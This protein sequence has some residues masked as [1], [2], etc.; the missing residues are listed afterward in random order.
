M[1]R[2]A[3]KRARRLQELLGF[4]GVILIGF[5]F[6]TFKWPDVPSGLTW[7]EGAE[8]LEAA[9]P[10]HGQFPLFFSEHG[11]HEPLLIYLQSISLKVFGWSVPSLRL[12]VIFIS[13]LGLAAT[14]L[15]ARKLF[16]YRV[17]WLATLLAGVTL[18]Q[19]AMSRWATRSAAI[20]V[21]DALI[22]FWLYRWVI[23][24][25][26]WRSAALCGLFT[27]LAWYSY[28]PARLLIVIP[29]L[30]G[31]WM[32]V[33]AKPRRALLGQA[34]LAGMV[35]AVAIAPLAW[36]VMTQPQALDRAAQLSV[37]SPGVTDRLGTWLTSVRVTALMFNVTGEIGWDRNISGLPIFDP[38]VSILMFGGIVLCLRGVRRPACALTL[39]W[40]ACTIPPLTLAIPFQGSADFGRAAAVAPAIFIL[41]AVAA[42]GLGRRWPSFRWLVGAGAVAAMVAGFVQYF[43][44]WAPAPQ[45]EP[46]FRPGVLQAAESAVSQLTVA[47]PPADLYYGE[48]EAYD[49]TADFVAAGLGIEHP[50]FAPRLVE[51]DASN[52]RVAP[53]PGSASYIIVDNRPAVAALPSPDHPLSATFGSALA[54]DGYDLPTSVTTGATLPLAIHWR[55]VQP[56]AGQLVFFAHLLDY[57]QKTTLAELDQN[58]FPPQDWRG[59]EAVLSTFSLQLPASA[60]PGVYWIELGA[61]TDGQLR[62]RTSGGDDR[63]LL[64][65]IVVAGNPERGATALTDLGGVAGLLSDEVTRDGDGLDVDLTWLPKH[66]LDGDYSVF[67]HVLDPAGKLV[68]QSDGPP[69][70]GAWPAGYW[71]PNV[72]V[73]DKHHVALPPA[74]P[75]G[76]YAVTVGLYRADTGQRLSSGAS[77]SPEMDSVLV[78]KISLE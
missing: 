47:T 45:R 26:P 25:R 75:R 65:P 56:P 78:G 13:T 32:L 58:G 3:G 30:T 41:P 20:T 6:R 8:G 76:Q 1:D 14:F 40:L 72:P 68:A 48:S 21:F 28:T 10:F 63:L 9:D 61:Y 74:L 31:L 12:P 57:T 77:A 67:V 4:A 22:L 39:L 36:S 53:P 35:G 33:R 2:L 50:E 24:H 71:L 73:D 37:L 42:A 19:V 46:A 66:A 16:G 64:G 17:A 29:A 60:A 38:V 44:I 70:N 5:F 62:L 11:G 59:G 51:Y 34:S 54:L 43:V 49:A 7:D 23:G 18:W 15:A 55:P 27:G 69:A 52:T